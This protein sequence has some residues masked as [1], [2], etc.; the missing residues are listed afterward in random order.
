MEF[1]KELREKAKES[2]KEDGGDYNDEQADEALNRLSGLAELLYECAMDDAKRKSRLRK[3]PDGFPCESSRS[4]CVCGDTI[5]SETGWYDK[6]GFKC[7]FCR[8]AV[9]EGVVPTFVCANRDSFLPM[10]RLTHDLK[11]KTPAIKKLIKEGRLNARVILTDEGKPHAYIFLRKE[12][13]ELIVPNNPIR[14]SYDR[15][16][17]KVGR[18]WAKE[19]AKEWKK[20]LL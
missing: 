10:W 2:F 18:R 7:H 5:N 17:E 14:K 9:A 1:S 6:Y 20:T 3:E 19:T 13:P 12:N 4:C 8:K 16:R 15:N 11:V